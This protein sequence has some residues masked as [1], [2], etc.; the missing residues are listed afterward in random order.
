MKGTVLPSL[1]LVK[2][3]QDNNA[4][5]LVAKGGYGVYKGITIPL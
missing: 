4:I 2:I 3:K 1:T 5:L